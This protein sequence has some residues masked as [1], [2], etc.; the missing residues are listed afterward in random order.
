[1]VDTAG[2]IGTRYARGAI[3]GAGAGSALLRTLASPP[4]EEPSP[5][6]RLLTAYFEYCVAREIDSYLA[7]G[8]SDPGSL[9]ELLQ[10]L[11][12][13]LFRI[14]LPQGEGDGAEEE[15]V[16]LTT[17][18]TSR[19]LPLTEEQG[20]FLGGR[21]RSELGT[22][23]ILGGTAA[24]ASACL[25]VELELGLERFEHLAGR[26]DGIMSLLDAFERGVPLNLDF[27][28]SF[29]IRAI[30]LDFKI[31]SAG[32]TPQLGVTS[33]LGRARGRA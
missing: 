1:M 10:T 30:D 28:L 14:L 23:M 3:D 18:V 6:E 15:G 8:S 17:R 16:Q 33:A 29:R 25:V 9:D 22:G 19:V 27:Q 31:A 5:Q 11:V 7:S 32:T 2:H 24:E 12:S 13:L 21:G 26:P 4:P 20:A